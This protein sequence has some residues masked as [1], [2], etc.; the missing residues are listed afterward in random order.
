MAI[1]YPLVH[2][3]IPSGIISELM[4]TYILEQCKRNCV[5]L[6]KVQEEEVSGKDIII[7]CDWYDFV[8]GRAVKSP[9][10]PRVPIQ[11]LRA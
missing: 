8:A 7:L 5:F 6:E 3:T 10:H 2:I 1:K 4:R 9:T 11:P